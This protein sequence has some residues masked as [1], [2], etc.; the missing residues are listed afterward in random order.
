[1]SESQTMLKKK[2]DELATA[3]DE[4]R[5][6]LARL[7]AGQRSEAHRQLIAL[8]KEA[9][10]WLEGPGAAPE[11]RPS[12]EAASLTRQAEQYLLE[13]RTKREAV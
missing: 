1:M 8:A 11:D 6:E 9:A 10:D 12:D 4:T 13:L 3:I 5:S 7:D 2:V